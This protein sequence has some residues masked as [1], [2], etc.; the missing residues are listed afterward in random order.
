MDRMEIDETAV[1]LRPGN[2]SYN[3]HVIEVELTENEKDQLE[4]ISFNP[5][6]W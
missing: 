3:G 2:R 1:E 4:E 6:Y 5:I